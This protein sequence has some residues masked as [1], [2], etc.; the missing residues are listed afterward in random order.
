METSTAVQPFGCR[1]RDVQATDGFTL[2]ETLIAMLIMTFGLLAAGQM[3]Y[4][5]VGSASLARSKGSAAV[6]AQDK[7]EFLAARYSRDKSAAD[8]TEGNHGP[9]RVEILNPAVNNALNR[10]NVAWVVS[11]VSDPR[12][13]KVIDARQVVVT[14]TPINAAN[15]ANLKAGFNKV[16]VV[17]AIFSPRII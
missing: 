13:G 8:L 1:W 3:I 7:L 5:A 16:V 17:S 15:A 9:E 11:T 2:I 12:A 10:F 14:V 4:V 6:V